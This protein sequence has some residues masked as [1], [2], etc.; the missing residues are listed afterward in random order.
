[1]NPNATTCI[2]TTPASDQPLPVANFLQSACNDGTDGGHL[3]DLNEVLGYHDSTDIPNYWAY[4]Q[5]FVLLDRMFAPAPTW[6]P[7]VHNYMVSGWNA[8]CST[9][10]CVTKID[11]V[12]GNKYQWTNITNLLDEQK[13]LDK[14]WKYYHGE[15][16]DPHCTTCD[17]NPKRCVK[18]TT[19]DTTSN[20]SA[21]Q[22]IPFWSPLSSYRTVTTSRTNQG[23]G[24]FYDDVAD[25]SGKSLP[26]VSWIVPGRAVSE[27]AGIIDPPVDIQAGQAYVTSIVNAIM[28]NQAL[29]ETTAI[30]LSWDDWGGFYDHMVP[31]NAFGDVNDTDNNH[32]YGLRVPGL[33]IS[34]WVKS[35]GYIDP[36]T[37]SHDAYLKFIEDLFLGSQK[38]GGSNPTLGPKDDRT[39]Q[40]EA[41]SA[42]GDLVQ[43]FNFDH[44]PL[45]PLL[46]TAIID[47]K[48]PKPAR[49]CNIP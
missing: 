5:N 17:T 8:D 14:P 36:Q 39:Q 15:C 7:V 46:A 13:S 27:H 43:E 30:F 35:K 23:L 10:P 31:P 38:I 1:M 45:M 18:T 9:S 42:L 49:A 11:S 32:R 37:L 33:L 26:A 4:A 28:R 47:P 40:R 19:C 48:Q 3:S 6:S 29:W 20:N 21:D 34:P 12:V 2:G 41:S 22:I 16:W 24:Q 25:S 44:A